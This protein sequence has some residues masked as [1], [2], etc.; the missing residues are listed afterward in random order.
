MLRHSLQLSRSANNYYY[1]LPIIV[2]AYH[3]HSG[4][5]AGLN[6]PDA[7]RTVYMHA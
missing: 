3:Y 5:A 4:I 1:V 7:R 2:S 6:M